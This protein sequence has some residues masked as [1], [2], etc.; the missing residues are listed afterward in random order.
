MNNDLSDLELLKKSVPLLMSWYG[1]NARVLPWRENNEPYRIWVSE[2]ML[3]QTRVETVI[4]Y[5]ERFVKE[6]PTVR[7]LAEVPDDKL[8]KLWEGL[9][10]YRRAINLKKGAQFVLKEFGGKIPNTL[11]QL[12]QIQGIGTYTAGAVASIAYGAL[13]P[14][15]D[16]N[17]IR[18]IARILGS[19][20]N[21]FTDRN[22][23]QL[24]DLVQKII[25]EGK[26]GDFNQALMELGALVCL[27]NTPPLCS[28]CPISALCRGYGQG[29]A[30]DLPQRPQKK[31]RVIE[32]KTVFL[33]TFNDL[34]AVR[35]RNSGSLL[36][37][38]WE[39]PN[40]NGS[41]SE[42]EIIEQLRDS[43]I[44][45]QRICHNG[46]VKHIFTHIEWHLTVYTIQAQEAPGQFQ[47]INMQ[48]LAKEIALPRAFRICLEKAGGIG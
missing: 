6:L 9:G 44:R 21:F 11:E 38:M 7:A 19:R 45:Y 37:G 48:Q 35:K 34:I 22:K 2:I 32:E 4:P 14:A 29:I 15:V 3:Q 23:K 12:K 40:V 47:W 36:A 43:G 20:V 25:P 24:E 17:V 10:Y 31:S 33:I 42:N 5:F 1:K 13:I 39:F 46:K 8:L 41:L 30:Y 18:V 16:G 27:P 28:Q 26:A